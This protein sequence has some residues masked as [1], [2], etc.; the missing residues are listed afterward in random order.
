MAGEEHLSVLEHIYHTDSV[1]F[2]QKMNS[3]LGSL[4]WH[5]T[6]FDIHL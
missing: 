2:L 3:S 5:E 1:T 6:M 4:D